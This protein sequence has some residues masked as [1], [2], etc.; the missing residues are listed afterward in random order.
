MAPAFSF[1]VLGTAAQWTARNPVLVLG[2]IGIET[3]TGKFKI[4]DG[5]S[6]WSSLSYQ[7]DAIGSTGATG[8]DGSVGATGATGIAGIT[9]ATG[10]AGSNGVTGATGSAG[11]NGSTGAT[12]SGVTGATATTNTLTT[13]VLFNSGGSI[14]GSANFVYVN[15][16]LT[17]ANTTVTS[18]MIVGVGVTGST[19]M[20][21]GTSMYIQ[22]VGEAMAARATLGTSNQF[23]WTTGAISYVSTT[24]NNW[25]ANIVNLPTNYPLRA[26]TY[27]FVI[28]QPAGAGYYCSNVYINSV[29]NTLRWANNTVPTPAAAKTEV[30]TL[31][32]VNSSAISG[33]PSWTVLGDYSTYG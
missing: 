1:K 5:T 22:Q 23:D 30:Q 9:G 32:L 29:S 24:S 12:G 2:E 3:D 27:T 4:G 20:F 16:T 19:G 13:Q 31:T 18:N 10:S 15:P 8:A 33:T 6:T 26:F 25:T 14:T 11:S 28:A 17:V 21:V 7:T